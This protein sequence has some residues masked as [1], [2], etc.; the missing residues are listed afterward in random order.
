[1]M[2][3]A[4][5][6]TMVYTDGR[7]IINLN[8]SYNRMGGGYVAGIPIPVLIFILVILLGIFILHITKFGRMCM[9][10]GATSM[11]PDCPASM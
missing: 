4:R 9:R 1:M 7:P 5:G 10:P 11:Q 6:L 2:T 3:A 8:D